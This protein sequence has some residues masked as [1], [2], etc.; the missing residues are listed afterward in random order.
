MRCSHRAVNKKSPKNTKWGATMIKAKIT[1]VSKNRMTISQLK[2]AC[3][4]VEEMLGNGFTT[5]F[6]IRNLELFSDSYARQY[7]GGRGVGAPLS[8]KY[9]ELWSNAANKYK[10]RILRGVI[11]PRDCV[12]V[13]HGTPR[14]GFANKVMELFDKKQLNEKTIN[15]LVQRYWKLAVITL[16]EDQRL[17]KVA[18]SKMFSSPD[19]RWKTAGIVFSKHV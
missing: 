7:F 17:N 5:N 6:A 2:M 16:E 3:R 9:I 19:K 11:K 13:E 1:K 14:R 8:A 15:T 12:R 18:R 10:S 4:H